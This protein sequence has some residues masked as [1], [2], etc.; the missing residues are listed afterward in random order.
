MHDCE[1]TLGY[2]DLSAASATFA[3]LLAV[4]FR[5]AGAFAGFAGFQAGEFNI[6]VDS[7]NG[8]F[9]VDFEIVAQIVSILRR[10]GRAASSAASEKAAERIVSAATASEEAVE[11]IER[12]A[13]VGGSASAQTI[14]AVPV[15]ELAFL[16]VAENLVGLRDLFELF[17]GFRVVR[18]LVRMILDGK[19]AVGSFDFDLFRSPFNPQDFVVVSH[20][21]SL[22]RRRGS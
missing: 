21:R 1:E 10:I 22:F 20:V 6:L 14:L 16:R 7:E 3:G 19:F 9:E 4:A 17:G 15:V 2:A 11:D 5:A 13:G 12:I 8:V 18:I